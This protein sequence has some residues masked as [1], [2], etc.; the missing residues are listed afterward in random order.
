MHTRAAAP[1]PCMT[2]GRP[3]H[4]PPT[5]AS[6]G[7]APA[8]G[9]E[10][11]PLSAP[12]TRRM[13]CSGVSFLAGRS[14][15]RLLAVPDG[16]GVL[17]RGG[18]A[19]RRWLPPLITALWPAPG[20]CAGAGGSECTVRHYHCLR[21]PWA[22]AV[23]A[24]AAATAAAV[25]VAAAPC[26]HRRGGAAAQQP[27]VLAARL[28]CSR[29]A[30]AAG[31]AAGVR[32]GRRGGR[33]RCG[34]KQRWCTRRPA[35]GIGVVRAVA[36]LSIVEG[37]PRRGSSAAADERHCTTCAAGRR[38]AASSACADGRR[39][40]LPHLLRLLPRLPAHCCPTRRRC[41]GPHNSGAAVAEGVQSTNI[42]AFLL[43][44]PHASSLCGGCSSSPFVSSSSSFNTPAAHIVSMPAQ[45]GAHMTKLHAH[46]AA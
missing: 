37:P 8:G 42:A 14:R 11:P 5:S 36:V 17:A 34:C 9:S 18:G 30:A 40:L 4:S 31:R 23:S 15:A 39:P 25:V 20:R 21:A 1:R 28:I 2:G 7:C 46:A 33:M 41:A 19:A 22:G 16:A 44:A 3:P 6:A 45:D 38:V 12:R 10:A 29:A 13:M 35:G 24:A 27:V 43:P 26:G 32:G